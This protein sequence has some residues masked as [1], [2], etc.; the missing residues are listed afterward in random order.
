MRVSFVRIKTQLRMVWC[1]AV[2]LEVATSVETKFG[3]SLWK[4]EQTEASSV[5]SKAFCSRQVKAT[6]DGIPVGRCRA[7]A[8]PVMESWLR[9]P[10]WNY[11]RKARGWGN[12]AQ[13]QGQ[14]E[15][16]DGNCE[17]DSGWW[18]GLVV[19]L[20][21]GITESEGERK[22]CQIESCDAMSEREERRGFLAV[23]EDGKWWNLC[24]WEEKVGVEEQQA[25]GSSNTYL[26]ALPMEILRVSMAPAPF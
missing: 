24:G 19:C 15:G 23:D 21:L 18:W 2:R 10:L 16:G 22:L 20:P 25:E 14:A 11:L 1:S 17:A 7:Q 6:A 3:G 8:F 5:C 12:L 13:A 4:E 26:E 9:S